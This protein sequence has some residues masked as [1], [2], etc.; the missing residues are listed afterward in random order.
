MKMAQTGNYQLEVALLNH[1]LPRHFLFFL[2]P[3]MNS[4]CRS[5]KMF[6]FSTYLI[7]LD[8]IP[9]HRHTE[10][11]KAWWHCKSFCYTKLKACV[12]DFSFFHQIIFCLSIH[13][14]S[15]FRSQDIQIFVF[16]SFP[17]FSLSTIGLEDDR[18]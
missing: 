12:H 18:R 14:K 6:Q 9:H 8:E 5:K 11:M 7:P 2:N 17:F 1:N 10:I 13:L 4:Y 15:S 16:L 3:I